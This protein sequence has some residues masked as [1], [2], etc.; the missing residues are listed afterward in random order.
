MKNRNKTIL[1]TVVVAGI[2]A[3]SAAAEQFAFVGARAMGMG[4]A[5]ASSAHDATAQ[6]HNP[7]VFGFMSQK[8][9]E[10]DS[11]ASTNEVEEVAATNEVADVASTNE[12]EEVAATNEDDS[13]ASTNNVPEGMQELVTLMAES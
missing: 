5:N 8:T 7:A 6:W 4:G 13:A 9:N 11:A 1:G 12:V 3:H 2:V 10:V